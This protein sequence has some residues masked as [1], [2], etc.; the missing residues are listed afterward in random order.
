MGANKIVLPIGGP[1]FL[2]DGYYFLVTLF[3][4]QFLV[5]MLEVSLDVGFVLF[6]HPELQLAYGCYCH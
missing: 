4:S 2:R 3:L 1:T 6:Y 5:K